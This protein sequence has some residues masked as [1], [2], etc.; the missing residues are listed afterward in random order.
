MIG[1]SGVNRLSTR[2]ITAMIA[3]V[4]LTAVTVGLPAIWILRRQL[5]QQAWAQVDQGRQAAAALYQ[6]HHREIQNLAT[7]TAQRPTLQQLLKEDPATLRRYLQDLQDGAGLANIVVCNPSGEIIVATDPS[8]PGDTCDAWKRGNDQYESYQGTI[9]MTAHQAI[10]NQAGL[11]GEVFV[12]NQLD[13]GFVNKISAETSLEHTLWFGDRLVA[14]SFSSDA[15]LV[16]RARNQSTI[17]EGCADCLIYEVDGSRYYATRVLLDEAGLYAE[18]ALDISDIVTSR[19]QLA[20]WM[21]A[22]IFGVVAAVS[23]LG[24]L[25][26]RQISRPLVDLAESAEDLRRGSLDNPVEI[27]VRVLEVAQVAQALERSRT[28]LLQTMTSLKT[29]R[30]WGEHLLASIVEGIVTLDSEG[31]ITYFSH[32]AERITGWSRSEVQGRTCDEVFHLARDDE[33]FSQV[34]PPAGKRAKADV[35]LAGKREAS[36]AITRAELAPTAASG[37]EVALVFRDISEEEAVHRLLGQFLANVAHEFRTPL[38]ALAASIELLLDQAPDLSPSELQELLISL[39]LGTLGLQTLIDNLLES[40]SIEAGH[41]RISPR[42]ADLGKI[43]AEAVDTIQPLLDKYGQRML[44]EVPVDFPKVWADPRRIVQV[45]VNLI[46]NANKYGPADSEIKLKVIKCTSE[47]R[48]EVADRGPGIPPEAR[49]DLFRRFVYPA[50]EAAASQTGAGLGLSVVKAIVE[51]HGG[52]VG[53]DDRPSGGSV[54]WFT[55]PTQ[56]MV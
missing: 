45:L 54:F 40:A 52:R 51:A 14:T 42:G 13:Q 29:E 10:D 35:Y 9:C 24:I 2:I 46:G 15:N 31:A 8:I 32:G 47:I 39:H 1:I 50:G 34:I 26:S 43:L 38:S 33:P 6:A 30:D 55:L 21:V 16:V 53:V 28:E 48:V 49:A 23:L 44:V 27:D 3:V 20:F 56:E 18:V 37:A 41:F 25:I 4:L 36:L 22:A 17:P 12:C 11:V 19:N 7:L 5:D